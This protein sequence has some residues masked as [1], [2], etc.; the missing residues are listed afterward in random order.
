MTLPE[1]R[2][3]TAAPVATTLRPVWLRRD[4][5]IVAALVVVALA[6]RVPYLGR[7]YWIDESV[8]LGIASHRLSQIPTLLRHDGSPPLFYLILHFWIA[9]FGTSEAAT[10]TLPLL[11][12]LLAVPAG[13][14]AGCRLFNRP[15]GI[16]A[17]ALLATNPFLNWYS[18]ETRMYTLMVLLSLVGVTLAWRAFQDRS[19]VHAA[20]AVVTYAA[21]LYTHNWGLYLA[22][23][24][25]LI[26]LWLAWSQGDRR[27]AAW[28]VAAGAATLALWAPWIPSFIFQAKNTAAPWAARPAIGDFFADPSTALGGTLG[29]LV[30]PALAGGVW[31]CR[32][33]SDRR[34]RF[35]ASVTGAIALVAT[36]AGFAGAQIQPSWTVRYLAIIVGPYLLAAAGVLAASLPG[37]RVLWVVCAA[38]AGW[39]VIGSLLPNPNGRYAKD[40]MA[41]LAAAV[42]PRMRAGDLVLVTQTEQTAVAYRYL[43]AGLRY[44]DPTGAVRDPSVVDW[45][46]IVSRLQHA[47]ACRAVAPAVD[48]LPVGDLVLEINPARKLG[49]SGSA[50]SKAVAKQVSADDNLLRRD[51]ALTVIGIYHPGLSP[52]PYSPVDGVLFLKT[53]TARACG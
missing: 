49:A 46:N 30:V 4:R 52:R 29:F 44:V 51:P 15:A 38:L 35:V 48:S 16:A 41:A 6:L 43:P 33:R 39:A 37:R 28:V 53:S 45:R 21:M 8:S 47:S 32:H 34:D 10:H 5:V 23:A 13:Y 50:W 18:T 9:L 25:G 24:T 14:W 17:A 12:S 31:A 40:N 27:L 26:L 11:V 42:A 19:L 3:P 22:G 36:V 7:S 1:V 20:G 2:T